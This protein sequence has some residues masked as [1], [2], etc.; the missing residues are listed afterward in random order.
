M[1]Y[2]EPRAPYASPP[3]YPRSGHHERTEVTYSH[4]AGGRRG[5]HEQQ[6]LGGACCGAGFG[7]LL[8]AGA[9]ALLW[10]NEGM[11]VRTA[12]SLDE[13]QSSLW[14]GELADAPGGALV[15]AAGALE[16]PGE[17]AD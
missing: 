9:T 16:T 8:L 2:L 15:H 4:A 7:A 14:R 11:A 17:L 12:R 3:A 13:A 5:G 1:A 10:V 6:S